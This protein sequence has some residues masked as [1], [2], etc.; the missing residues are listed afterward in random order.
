M[1]ITGFPVLIIT[2]R[3]K[4]GTKISNP[5]GGKKSAR[6]NRK[7]TKLQRS[8]KKCH[9]RQQYYLC[10]CYEQEKIGVSDRVLYRAFPRVLFR[11]HAS[12]PRLRQPQ[13]AGPQPGAAFLSREPG[14]K[15]GDRQGLAREGLRSG[16]FFYDLQGD[17]S[18]TQP[19]YER[20]RG[21]D[22]Q[23]AR[24]PHSLLPRGPRDGQRGQDEA[25]CRLTRRRPAALVV[26]DRPERQ[27]VPAGP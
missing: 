27:L 4:C 6:G 21:S 18:Q 11:A 9:S 2:R 25:L 22:G 20:S 8:C 13:P 24:F 26:P 23:P 17:L 16:I 1:L 5:R 19:Q 15:A 7:S 10:V 3:L 12:C 14:R